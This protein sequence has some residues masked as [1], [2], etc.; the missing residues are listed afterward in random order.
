VTVVGG[1]VGPLDTMAAAGD[2]GGYALD[3]GMI[4]KD[5]IFG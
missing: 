1:A 2:A 3:F 4:P 5:L